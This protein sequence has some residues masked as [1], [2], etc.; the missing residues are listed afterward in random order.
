MANLPPIAPHEAVVI[1]GLE[2]ALAKLSPDLIDKPLRD[3]WGKAALAVE[4][5]WRAKISVDTGR[6]RSSV[7]HIIADESPPPW[8]AIG[9]NYMPLAYLESGTGLFAQG[10]PRKGGRHWPPGDA[11]DVWAKRHGFSSGAQV[12]AII[13]KRGGLKPRWW[14]R[15]SVRESLATIQRFVSSLADDIAKRWGSG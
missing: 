15:D 10:E 3:F 7:T 6:G 11:L 1:E 2:E 13:G 14:L 4:N 9:T 5:T 12:A 8:V